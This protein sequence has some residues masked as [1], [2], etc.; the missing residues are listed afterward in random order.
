MNALDVQVWPECPLMC[1]FSDAGNDETGETLGARRR[2]SAKARNREGVGHRRCRGLYGDLGRDVRLGRVGWNCRSRLLCL[3]G[4]GWMTG[5]RGSGRC[6]REL[7]ERLRADLS[8]ADKRGFGLLL[9]HCRAIDGMSVRCHIFQLQADDVA[10]SQLTIDGQIEHREIACSPLD[11]QFAPNRPKCLGRSGGF[12]PVSLPLFQG[13]RRD[14]WG[15]GSS[16][17]CMVMLLC[18]RG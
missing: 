12:V 13:S 2:K 10:A 3:P 4:E 16:G 8:I 17:S 11:L 1:R 7:A 9:A 5:E 14:A 18:C 15:I 6:P